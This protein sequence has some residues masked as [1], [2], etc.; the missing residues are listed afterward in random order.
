MIHILNLEPFG[1]SPK[2]RSILEECGEVTAGPLTR[3]ELLK[4]IPGYEI[5]V[6]RLSHQ[7]D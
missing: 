4:A 5:I 6:V 3:S 2:A 1:Y 7:S